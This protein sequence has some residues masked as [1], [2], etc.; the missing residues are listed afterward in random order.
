MTKSTGLP[1][2]M[3]ERLA[4]DASRG[5]TELIYA[6]WQSRLEKQFEFV[7]TDVLAALSGTDPLRTVE[8]LVMERQ[9]Q[10]ATEKAEIAAFLEAATGAVAS[11]PGVAFEPAPVWHAP[12]TPHREW[13]SRRPDRFET[14]PWVLSRQSAED[15]V[16]GWV[17]SG[18]GVPA[19]GLPMGVWSEAPLR[20]AEAWIHEHPA[21]VVDGSAGG[22][23][24]PADPAGGA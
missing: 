16:S 3:R 23:F 8:R 10:H 5:R 1:P 19:G 13:M 15:G 12:M 20:A 6:R 17:L 24:D 4:A 22:A 11:A 21:D 14:G 7:L 18:P 2:G 9:A